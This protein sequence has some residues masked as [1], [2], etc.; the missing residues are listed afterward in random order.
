MPFACISSIVLWW[1]TPFVGIIPDS[2]PFKQLRNA[3]QIN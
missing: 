2:H 3:A 1:H